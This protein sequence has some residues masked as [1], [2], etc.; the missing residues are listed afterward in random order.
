MDIGYT[1]T[2]Y[3]H[4]QHTP[5]LVPVRT[6]LSTVSAPDS[7]FTSFASTSAMLWRHIDVCDVCVLHCHRAE[8]SLHISDAIG[9]KTTVMRF[10]PEWWCIYDAL[11]ENIMDLYVHRAPLFALGCIVFS[12]YFL[13]VNASDS[14]GSS[15]L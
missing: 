11:N 1:I 3:S 8:F 15:T 6:I 13:N 9:I 4:T 14:H 5:K 7:H 12:F 2:R 10:M